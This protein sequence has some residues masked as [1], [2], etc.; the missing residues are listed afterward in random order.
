[1]TQRLEELSPLTGANAASRFIVVLGEINRYEQV[2]EDRY[3]RGD[4][5]TLKFALM[6]VFQELARNAELQG[7]AEWVGTERAAILFLATGS[8]QEMEAKIR[9]FLRRIAAPG[10]SRICGS[11][12]ASASAPLPPG[13]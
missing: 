9:V 8:D 10:S 1:M 12:S 13:R 2:F 6:N 11:R 5:N 3:T 4:Q 7:W